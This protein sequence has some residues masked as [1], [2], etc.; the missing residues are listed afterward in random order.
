[1]PSDAQLSSGVVVIG[2]LA[3][4]LAW[5][6]QILPVLAAFIHAAQFRSLCFTTF[7]VLVELG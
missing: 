5:V 1:M 3:L 2:S 6:H 7:T 4:G